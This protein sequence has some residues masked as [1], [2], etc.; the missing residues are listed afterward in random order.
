[1][2]F[3]DACIEIHGDVY[4]SICRYITMHYVCVYIHIYIYIY[5]HN[6]IYIYI[7]IYM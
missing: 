2:S 1:M 5:S 4:M 7:Y 3:I 6:C